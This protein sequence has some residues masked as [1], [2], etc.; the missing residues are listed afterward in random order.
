MTVGE[1][2]ELLDDVSDEAEVVLDTPDGFW[3][4][5]DLETTKLAKSGDNVGTFTISPKVD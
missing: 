5:A 2:K 4:Y 3:N 1:L